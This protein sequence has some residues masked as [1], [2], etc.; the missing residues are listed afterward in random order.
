MSHYLIYGSKGW[1]ASQLLELL[2]NQNKEKEKE[3]NKE[4]NKEKENKNKEEIKITLSKTRVDNIKELKQELSDIKPTHVIAI[5]GRT[6]GVIE[7]IIYPTIDYLEQP[8][9]LQ[10][11]IRD[12]LFSQVVLA[13]LC[14]DLNIHLTL[15]NTGCIFDYD[16]SHPKEQEING[17]TEEDL[18]NFFGS[19]YSVV[20]GFTDQLMHLFNDSCLNLRIR[21]PISN[22]NCSRNFIT[23]ITNYKKIC[24]IKNSM[25]VLPELLPIMLDLISKK[26]VGTVNLVNPGL[27][28]HNEIL[29]M[30]KDIVDK[31]FTWENFDILEQDKILAAK[32]SNNYLDTTLLCKL[33]P[34]VMNIKDA[35][36]EVLWKYNKDL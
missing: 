11:N 6:H 23:K 8:N 30:Y 17:F 3:K 2:E 31:T 21:M 12:N 29:S 19:S 16:A 20:K 7:N 36:K 13:T 24:S 34:E 10:E 26:H 35:V 33:Y 9:K 1:I 28:S 32:R 25:S 15:L 4:K 22:E 5:I 27:I 14:K 18:P